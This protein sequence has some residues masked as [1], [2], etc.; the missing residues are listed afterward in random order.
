MDTYRAIVNK[1]DRRNFLPK[2]LPEEALQRILQAG[3]MTGS[4]KNAEPNRFVVVKNADTLAAMGAAGGPIMAWLANA[5]V[6]HR[7]SPGT[8][9]MPGHLPRYG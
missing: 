9:A 2:P 6:G 8:T 5:A 4:S 1:R 7:T 3:R